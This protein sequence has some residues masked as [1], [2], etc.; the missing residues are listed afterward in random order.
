MEISFAP[1]KQRRPAWL[2]LLVKGT[3][4]SWGRVWQAHA[5]KIFFDKKYFALYPAY[6]IKIGGKSAGVIILRQEV[7]ALVIYFFSLL[8]EFRGKGLG[9]KILSAAKK[10]AKAHNCKFLRVDTYA[11]FT[12][13]KFYLACGFKKCGRVKNYNETDDD[14]IFLYKR[15]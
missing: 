2:A 7:Q 9:C 15:I 6:E 1:M 3:T 14:Q 4:R 11:K 5:K 13:R 8:P 10:V 12:S